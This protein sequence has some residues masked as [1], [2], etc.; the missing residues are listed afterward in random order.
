MTPSEVNENLWIAGWA[1]AEDKMTSEEVYRMMSATSVKDKE[2]L[3]NMAIGMVDF[4]YLEE[5][6]QN[7]GLLWLNRLALKRPNVA[8]HL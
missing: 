1:P 8:L 2:L 4:H 3:L 5:S 7:R 6:V